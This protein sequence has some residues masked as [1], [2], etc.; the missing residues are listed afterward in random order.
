[1]DIHVDR[2]SA[3]IESVATS[4]FYPNLLT[5]LEQF[6]A[7]DN[8]IIYAFEQGVPPRCL[9]K[10]EKK[11]SD[12]V[13]QLY[14]Q[15]AYL[16]DPFYQA[17]TDGAETDLFTLREL[18]PVGFYHTDYYLNFYSKTGWQDEAGVLLKLSPQRQLGLFFGNE[19]RLFLIQKQHQKNLRTALEIIRSVA[20]LHGEMM[21]Q[22]PVAE[23]VCLDTQIRYALT[24]RECEVVELILQGKGSPQI[25]E[26]LFIS[27]GTVKNHRKNIYQKLQIRS[28]AE[29][30]SLFM[31]SPSRY[32]A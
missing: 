1:M 9:T 13:N 8:A 7:F 5:W 18:A 15:G 21:L 30:F 24:P 17:L 31:T 20:R 3:V 32:F 14:Q 4:K 22:A 27:T 23:M 12:V 26:K 10:A 16:Q 11:N 2:L 28:Q 19:D 29:L 25:A 6:I